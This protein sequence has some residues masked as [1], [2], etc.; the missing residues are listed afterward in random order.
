MLS[1]CLQRAATISTLLALSTIGGPGASVEDPARAPE[2]VLR[3]AGNDTLSTNVHPET[4]NL[5]F[6][7]VAPDKLPMFWGAYGPLPPQSPRERVGGFAPTLAR[8]FYGGR[9]AI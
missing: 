7:R 8:G 4:Q 1:N 6:S 2:D 3:E 9:W 5:L